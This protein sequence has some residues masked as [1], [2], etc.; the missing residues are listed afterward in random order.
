MA[1]QKR[2]HLLFTVGFRTFSVYQGRRVSDMIP[3]G[4]WGN[5]VR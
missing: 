4:L 5:M 1:L 3:V 2:G